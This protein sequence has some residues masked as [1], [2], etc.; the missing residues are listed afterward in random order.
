MWISKNELDKL[1]NKINLLESRI[2]EI[3]SNDVRKLEYLTGKDVIC[4]FRGIFIQEVVTF[5]QREILT[6]ILNHLKIK[7]TKTVTPEKIEIKLESI[8]KAKK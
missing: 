8:E 7:P 2:T 5:T 1:I 6:A 4:P 3:E